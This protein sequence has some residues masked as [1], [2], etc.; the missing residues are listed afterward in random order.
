MGKAV[1]CDLQDGKGRI[2]LYV[3]VDELG[4]EAFAKFKR[5]TSATSWAWK[6]RSLRPSGARSPVKAHKVTLLSK[7][8]QPLPEKFHGLTDRRCATA[9]AM[10]I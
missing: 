6:A 1:F 5:P 4:E 8:L 7:S 2:Q 3:R 10:W 9:S